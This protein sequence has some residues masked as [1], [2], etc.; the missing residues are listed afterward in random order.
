[1]VQSGL[2]IRWLTGTTN[3]EI[4]RYGLINL[5]T[6]TPF[7]PIL[8]V[9]F[10]LRTSMQAIGQK[11][12]PVISSAIELGVRVFGAFVMVPALGYPGV[13]LSTS[14]TWTSMTVF[15]FVCYLLKTRKMLQGQ[16]SALTLC[17]EEG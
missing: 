16:P 3:P 8:G 5:R 13:A 6:V 15:I 14:L 11:I 17:S 9:L 1:M 4:V 10:I 2:F 12:V 7:Y